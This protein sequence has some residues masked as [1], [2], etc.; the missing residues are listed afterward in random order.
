ML[1]CDRVCGVVCLCALLSRGCRAVRARRCLC[2]CSCGRRVCCSRRC[3]C[4]GSPHR[5]ENA[6]CRGASAVSHRAAVARL[7]HATALW[8]SGRRAR[9]TTRGTAQTAT[10]DSA[11]TQTAASSSSGPSDKPLLC[12]RACRRT[13]RDRSAPRIAATQ[14]SS[15]C[16][17]HTALRCS[18]VSSD[19]LRGSES[20]ARGGERERGRR[21]GDA[22]LL[23]CAALALSSSFLCPS[24]RLHYLAPSAVAVAARRSRR[25]RCFAP[26]ALLPRS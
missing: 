23:Q 19:G 10:R 11:A 13:S 9:R 26:K 8:P 14:H 24:A 4:D 16:T 21:A 22:D 12:Q 5:W 20:T 1:S 18:D 6:I 3:G 17:R 7:A 15:H 25:R 2:G